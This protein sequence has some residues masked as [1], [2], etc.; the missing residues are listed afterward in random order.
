MSATTADAV[1]AALKLRFPAQSHALMFEVAPATGG[2]TRYADAVA[3]GLWASHG[4]LVQGIEIKVS[5][6]DFLHE[7]KQPEKS[8]PVMRY[9]GRWWLACPRGMVKPEELPPTWGMLEL[10]D[11]GVLMPKIKAPILRPVPVDLAFFA[12]LC[13][14]RAGRDE[15]MT[16]AAVSKQVEEK[17]RDIQRRLEGDHAKRLGFN[18]QRILDAESTLGAIQERTGIDLTAYGAEED[19]VAAIN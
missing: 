18:Q 14:R 5:R 19:I 4:H 15:A 11:N 8:E 17:V 9:C 2:G 16:D 10:G 13:R 1:R 12:S 3:V 6:A 7:M